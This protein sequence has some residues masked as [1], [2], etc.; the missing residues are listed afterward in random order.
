MT[1]S[2]LLEPVFPS[3]AQIKLHGYILTLLVKFAMDEQYQWSNVAEKLNL[4]IPKV[5]DNG[6]DAYELTEDECKDLFHLII[7]DFRTYRRY[8]DSVP[9]AE[10]LDELLQVMHSAVVMD[11]QY[12]LHMKEKQERLESKMQKLQSPVT[13]NDDI[14]MSESGIAENDAVTETETEAE[15]DNNGKKSKK[16][17]PKKRKAPQPDSIVKRKKLDA[18]GPKN[19]KKMLTMAVTEFEDHKLGYLFISMKKNYDARPHGCKKT[20]DLKT[21]KTNVAKGVYESTIQFFEDCMLMIS[22]IVMLCPEDPVVKS[23]ALEMMKVV[24]DKFSV[25]ASTQIDEKDFH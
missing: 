16:K 7:K 20:L 17:Q 5:L 6:Y 21:I 18:S 11:I 10:F 14:L 2:A 23:N 9:Q 4:Q 3:L 1:V 12:D 13:D 8:P 19:L 24:Q 15:A 22:N 25:M